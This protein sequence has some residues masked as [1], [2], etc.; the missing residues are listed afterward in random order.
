M[1]AIYMYVDFNT[2]LWAQGILPR[3][4][5]PMGLEIREYGMEDLI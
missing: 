3:Y 5:I 2:P 1:T 4:S